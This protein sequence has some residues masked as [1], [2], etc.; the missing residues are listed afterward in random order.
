MKEF[1]VSEWQR[2]NRTLNS[3]K[4]LIES[5]PDS[6]AS[7]AYYAAFHALTAMFALKGQFFNKHSALR[8][9]V[10]RDLI[11]AGQWPQELGIAYDFLLEMREVGDYGGPSGVSQSDAQMAIEKAE[12]IIESVKGNNPELK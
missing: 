2:A 12:L 10:H 7:R 4:M 3:G 1:A 8:T 11:K 6:A 5:D 9:A